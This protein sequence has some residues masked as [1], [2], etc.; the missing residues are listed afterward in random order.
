ML[1]QSYR[2][3]FEAAHELG[4]N[5]A[6]QPEHPYARIHGH[7]FEA[8]VTLRA[9]ADAEKAGS[10]ILLRS[11]PRAMTSERCSTTLF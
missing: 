1:E 3:T 5:V 10:K 6:D 4:Q 2:F 7:S 9:E 8:T 11:A